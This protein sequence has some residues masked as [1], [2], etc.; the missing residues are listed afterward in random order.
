[1]SIKNIIIKLI[2]ERIEHYDLKLDTK[3]VIALQILK[4]KLIDEIFG[5]D[6]SQQTEDKLVSVLSKDKSSQID[7][8]TNVTGEVKTADT[9][10]IHKVNFNDPNE[11][12]TKFK[13]EEA[14]EE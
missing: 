8:D 7:T 2:D 1:M 13:L 14:K 3:S 10:N 6:D 4:Q 5:F 12:I 11:N 9:N